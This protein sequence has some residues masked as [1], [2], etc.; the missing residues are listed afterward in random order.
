[1]HWKPNTQV[2]GLVVSSSR[3]ALIFLRMEIALNLQQE[4]Q[5]QTD[6]ELFECLRLGKK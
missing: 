1:M 5:I 6:K 2:G 4:Q 3:S